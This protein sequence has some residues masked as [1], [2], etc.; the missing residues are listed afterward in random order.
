MFLRIWLLIRVFSKLP[1]LALC[2]R[3][4][5]RKPKFLLPQT[6]Q[7][8][9]GIISANKNHRQRVEVLVRKEARKLQWQGYNMLASMIGQYDK[10]AVRREQRRRLEMKAA[11]KLREAD[12]L[13]ELAYRLRFDAR[14]ISE[15]PKGG[16][17]FSLVWYLKQKKVSSWAEAAARR[18]E[19]QT[20]LREGKTI[21][22]IPVNTACAAFSY[23]RRLVALAHR[24]FVVAIYCYDKRTIAWVSES[25]SQMSNEELAMVVNYQG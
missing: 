14:E 5:K 2:R 1:A 13:E 9:N 19:H 17:P 18:D 15:M 8:Y 7:Y 16:Y 25:P 3:I 20:I 22:S 4:F 6:I 24:F 12:S 10:T 23:E 21:M 11:E